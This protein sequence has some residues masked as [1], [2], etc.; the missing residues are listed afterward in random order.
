MRDTPFRLN[1]FNFILK[2]L[3]VLVKRIITTKF[4]RDILC[5]TETDPNIQIHVSSLTTF[6]YGTNEF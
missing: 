6:A 1:A 4:S 3:F 2:I 5:F